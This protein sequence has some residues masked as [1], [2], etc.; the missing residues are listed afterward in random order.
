V[1]KTRQNRGTDKRGAARGDRPVR[2]EGLEAYRGI[3]ALSV[4]VFHAYQYS[5]EGLQLDRF[6]YEG[7]KWHTLFHNLD[8]AVSWFFVLSGFLV[9]LPFSYAAVSQGSRRSARS[10]L[11]RRALRILP[12]YYVAI[13]V[14]WGL[15]YTGSREE[16][17]SLLQH[18]TFTHVFSQENL[19]RI[20]GPA[21]SLADEVIFYLMVAGLGPLVYL[22]CRHLNAQG[23]RAALIG[24]SVTALALFSVGYK[25]WA[26]Y[27][28]RIPEENYP[29]YF[30]PLA[31]L[32]SFALGMLLAVILA[33][34]WLRFGKLASALLYLGGVAFLAMS[35]TLRDTHAAVDLYF[36]TL[37]AVAFA[38]VLAATVVPL[39]QEDGRAAL[40]SWLLGSPVLVY[41]GLI[42]YSIYMW[43]EPI[44]LE[45][46]SRG[47]LMDKDPQFFPQNAL[48]LVVVSIAVAAVSYSLIERPAMR[49][50]QIFDRKHPKQ[51]TQE[52]GAGCKSV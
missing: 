14:V 22:A 26:Y 41:V 52:E 7:S 42:S 29:V 19:F 12:L 1:T 49:L 45:L 4:V 39:A 2:F 9:F 20:I 48:V 51:D 10:F 25:W 36:Y 21:W 34:G 18:L 40:L 15:R 38:M 46:G 23:K 43:H 17:V 30:G 50:Y 6:V 35:F 8:G 5:R 11:I 24:A 33:A 31:H 47:F 16:W 13:L 32:D 37:C 3:A 44:L 28:A 27:V